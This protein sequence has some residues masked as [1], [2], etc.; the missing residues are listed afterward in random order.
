MEL[1]PLATSPPWGRGPRVD[2]VERAWVLWQRRSLFSDS[3]SQIKHTPRSKQH[4]LKSWGWAIHCG[5]EQSRSLSQNRARCQASGGFV[6]FWESSVSSLH[7]RLAPGLPPARPK[8]QLLLVFHWAIK[9]V[10]AW[11]WS[12]GT[13]WPQ[14]NSALGTEALLCGPPELAGSSLSFL[15]AQG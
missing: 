8:E 7:V 15:R 11:G 2:S 5:A 1:L 4:L 10:S 12:L 6:V 14:W 13:V 3:L 9:T